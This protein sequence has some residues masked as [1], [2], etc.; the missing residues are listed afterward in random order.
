MNQFFR[1]LC[2]NMLI[3]FSIFLI[4]FNFLPAQADEHACNFKSTPNSDVQTIL[5]KVFPAC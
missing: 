3:Y 4:A 2:V 5:Q 1:N